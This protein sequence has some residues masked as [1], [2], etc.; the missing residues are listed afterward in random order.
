MTRYTFPDPKTRSVS[1]PT[2][3]CSRK[4]IVSL[5]NY[6]HG[7]DKTYLTQEI[8]DWFRATALHLGWSSVVFGPNAATLTA[9]V[10][11]D[12]T[13]SAKSTNTDKVVSID[14]R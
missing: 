7:T 8:K 10:V 9:K 14:R 4:K 5:Y 3:D 2:D 1:K 6:A 12:R 11:L 13:A